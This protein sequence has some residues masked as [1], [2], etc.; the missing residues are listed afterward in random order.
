MRGNGPDPRGNPWTPP[1]GPGN[2]E[3]LRSAPPMLP[4]APATEASTRPAVTV[5]RRPRPRRRCAMT[6]DQ[7]PSE[8]TRRTS[9]LPP[10]VPTPPTLTDPAAFRPGT[11]GLPDPA[12]ATLSTPSDSSA[13][14]TSMP[15][16]ADMPER[17]GRFH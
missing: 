3:T 11:L 17:V 15:G 8:P 14:L 4:R 5:G 9:D 12:R 13:S 7:A 1:T 2:I 16:L 6:P 10:E